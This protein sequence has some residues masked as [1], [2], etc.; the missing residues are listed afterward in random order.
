MTQ[1]EYKTINEVKDPLVFV[2]KTENVAYGD[3]VEVETAD[4]QIKT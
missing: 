2:E 3:I 4:G 1:K